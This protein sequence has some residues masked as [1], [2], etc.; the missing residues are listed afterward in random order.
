MSRKTI[1]VIYLSFL[2]TALFP[3]GIR[4]S[5]FRVPPV[6]VSSEILFNK[7]EAGMKKSH[8]DSIIIHEKINLSLSDLLSENTSVFI[9]DHGRGALATASFRGT[10]PSHTQVSWNGLNINSP[11]AGMVDFSLIPVYIIDELDIRHGTASIADRSGGIGGSINI[12]NRADWNNRLS[13]KYIQGLGSF[14]TFDEFLQFSAGNSKLQS[15]TRLYH[16]YSKNDY[17]F[18]NRGIGIIDQQTGQIVNP[19]DTNKR[20]SYRK[21]GLMQELYLRAGTGDVVSLR[22]WLQDASRSIPRATSYEG[23]DNSNLNRQ[24]DSDHR[25]TA[26]WKHF[27]DNSSL[28]LRTGYSLKELDYILEN[29]VHGMG[30]IPVIYSESR[31]SVFSNHAAYTLETTSGF[32]FRTGIDA[33]MYSV[34][35]RDTVSEK[36]YNERR[37]EFSLFF[38]LQ[39]QFA[40]RVNLNMMLRRDIID[41]KLSPFIPYLGFDLALVENRTLI[42]KGNIAGNYHHPSLNDLYWEPGG[43]PNLLPERGYSMEMSLEYQTQLL[44]HHLEAGLTAYRSDIDNWI[45]WI[46]GYRGYWEPLNIS[47]VLSKGIEFNLAM[48]GKV[49]V[50]EYRMLGTYAYTN[51]VNYGDTGIWGDESYGKQLVYVPLHSGNIM[52][53]LLYSGFSLGWQHNSYSERFTTSSNDISRRDRLYPYFMNK[54]SLGKELRMGNVLFSGELSINNLFNEEYHS[55]LY[56]PMPGR[57]YMFLLMLKF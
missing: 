32:S 50:V 19:L 44:S 37:S 38:S 48:E 45:L 21:Y 41:K 51:S 14:S 9:K 15:K 6:T 2:S 11:M 28:E 53:K 24:S 27:N 57:N 20:A 30:Y 34:N 10:A 47:R 33:N 7:A 3:Q 43:N 39:K 4:D 40:E 46:P 12:S 26:G 8:V 29:I 54:L 23:P 5:V 52:I 36:G 31:Q 42:L 16:N 13:G 17:T 55:I 22:Y 18:I 49:G 56:R 25:I 35:T 1:I